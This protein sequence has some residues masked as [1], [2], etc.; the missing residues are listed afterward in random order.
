MRSE[1]RPAPVPTMDNLQQ[2]QSLIEESLDVMDR[3]D[4]ECQDVELEVQEAMKKRDRE[5]KDDHLHSVPRARKHS[6]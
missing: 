6:R 4:S 2:K 1:N 3:H 5:F